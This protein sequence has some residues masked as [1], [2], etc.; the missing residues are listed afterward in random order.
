MTS[1]LY[2]NIIILS[3]FTLINTCRIQLVSVIAKKKIH[4][5]VSFRATYPPI[6]VHIAGR[7]IYPFPN[8][9]HVFLYCKKEDFHTVNRRNPAP[10]GMY[11]TLYIMG[12]LP[13]QLVSRISSINS[14]LMPFWGGFPLIPRHENSLPR[15]SHIARHLGLDLSQ[16]WHNST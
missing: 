13:Y 15:C 12:Y 5:S 8:V 3:I 10:L 7:K 11:K 16:S 2:T 6:I 1:I 4:P 14:T 9:F